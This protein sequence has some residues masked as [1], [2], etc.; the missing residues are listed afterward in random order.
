MKARNELIT[1][2]PAVLLM[3]LW[4]YAAVSKIADYEKFVLQIQLA[5]IPMMKVLGPILGWLIPIVEFVLVSLLF[6]DRFRRLGLW[7]SFV[8]LTAF[9]V[10]I[11]TMLMSGLNLPCTCGGLISK[12]QWKGHLVFNAIFMLISLVPFLCQLIFH[13]NDHSEYSPPK[14]VGVDI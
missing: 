2:I 5:P 7:L 8:L 1:F 3:M 12:L 4:G 9:E 10:Y 13:R 11:A 14:G 6:T